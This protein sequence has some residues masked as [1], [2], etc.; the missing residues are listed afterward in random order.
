MT[1]APAGDDG[2]EE[3]RLRLLVLVPHA[4]RLDAPHGGRALASLLHRLAERHDVALVC[5]RGE[6]EARVDDALRSWCS[7]V[8]EVS[9][10]RPAPGPWRRRGQQVAKLF[11]GPPSLIARA[12]APGY[13]ERVRA[14]A[15]SWRPDVVQIELLE[16]AQYLAALDECAAP[17]VL[18]D[19]DPGAH[20]AEDW[21]GAAT[22]PRRAWRRLDVIAWRRFSRKAFATVDRVVV[23]TDRDR[24]A[25]ERLAPDVGV[26]TIPLTIELPERSLDPKGGDPPTL[27]FFGGY[28]HAPNADA[29][30]RLLNSIFPALRTAHPRLVLQLVGDKPTDQM[31]SLAGD[32]IVVPGRV[33]S[34]I[35]YLDAATVVAAPLRLGGG[36]RVKV[37]ET[38]AAGKALVA[39]TRALEGLELE[40]GEEALV[41]DT[42][43]DFRVAISELLGDEARRVELGRR[44]RGW[45]EAHL[46][47]HST[48]AAY[49]TLYRELLDVDS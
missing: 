20:A 47:P 19:H 16:T 13:A 37:L 2:L 44:A 35:P 10:R 8:E 22:G 3:R 25:V 21:S 43:E 12:A 11:G 27:L 49:E 32:G 9:V 41:A 29:A 31:R 45:A 36:M 34:M 18:V 38:L 28:G 1:V 6:D 46:D 24:A 26:R 15:G 5:I 42:D 23:F 4:P 39:S 33:E 17:R 30:G 14:I 40:A 7:L 48:A